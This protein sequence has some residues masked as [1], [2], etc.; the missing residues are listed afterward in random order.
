MKKREFLKSISIAAMGIPF[1][2]TSIASIFGANNKLTSKQIVKAAIYPPIG[3]MRALH[4]LED[5]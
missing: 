4:L 1:I 2:N 5:I 3:V